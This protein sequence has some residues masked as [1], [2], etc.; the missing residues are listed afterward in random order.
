MKYRTMTLEGQE[1]DGEMKDSYS[2]FIK[3][4]DTIIMGWNTYHQAVTE[5]S[6]ERFGRS[7]R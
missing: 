7:S 5:L 2:E 1:P 6:R 4:I 3:D